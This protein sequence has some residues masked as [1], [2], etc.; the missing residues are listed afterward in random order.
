[1]NKGAFT[2]DK[3]KVR[4]AILLRENDVTVGG[5]SYGFI[6]AVPD[7]DKNS[8]GLLLSN[9]QLRGTTSSRVC[10]TKNDLW[11]MYREAIHIFEVQ[12]TGVCIYEGSVNFKIWQNN[13]YLIMN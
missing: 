13:Q 1:M 8:G 6:Y 10:E 11:R 3:R 2:F 9:N 7:M 4:C 12:T 5:D